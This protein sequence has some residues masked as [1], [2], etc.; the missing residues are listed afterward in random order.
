MSKTKPYLSCPLGEIIAILTDNVN[1]TIIDYENLQL[2]CLEFTK[3]VHHLLLSRTGD[4]CAG[5][6]NC[7]VTVDKIDDFHTSKVAQLCPE[8][9]ASIFNRICLSVV[10]A[11]LK[12]TGGLA[13]PLK[14]VL[15]NAE[16]FVFRIL[17]L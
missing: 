13:K 14:T 5:R 6:S 8:F 15:K 16:N 10:Y 17:N 4:Q 12:L 11:C 2:N 9:G 3:S 1:Q 7:S